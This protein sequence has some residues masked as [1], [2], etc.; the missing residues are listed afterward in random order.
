V[1]QQEGQQELLMFDAVTAK[2]LDDISQGSKDAAA[3][4]TGGFAF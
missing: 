3:G 1:R 2:G 4:S